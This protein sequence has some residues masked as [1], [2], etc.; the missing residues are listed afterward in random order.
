MA[1]TAN[2]PKNAWATVTNHCQAWAGDVPLPEAMVN[3]ISVRHI[4][5]YYKRLDEA[6]VRP[7]SIGGDH[8]ITGPILKAISGPNAKL[9]GG[10]KVALVH[11]DAHTDAYDH[12]PH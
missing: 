10:K 12:I 3:D 5:A 1:N 8:S 2:S 7:V 4:E 6:G 9:T 11:F